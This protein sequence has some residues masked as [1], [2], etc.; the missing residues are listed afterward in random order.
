M[1]RLVLILAAL[2]VAAP[3]LADPGEWL[4]WNMP[5]GTYA[6]LPLGTDLTSGPGTGGKDNNGAFVRIFGCHFGAT[7]GPSTVTIG[8]VEVVGYPVWNDHEIAVQLGPNVIT[9]AI[10]VTTSAGAS[11][12]LETNGSGN[13]FTFTVRPGNIYFVDDTSPASPGSGTYD[14]P[15]RSPSSFMDNSPVINRPPGDILYIR[16]GTYAGQYMYPFTAQWTFDDVNTGGTAGNPIAFVGYPG[17][18]PI[19]SGQTHVAKWR[20]TATFASVQHIVFANMEL[21]GEKGP[22]NDG[23]AGCVDDEPGAADIRVVNLKS[24]DIANISS[25]GVFKSAADD[26]VFLFNES[27][28]QHGTSLSH[29]FYP[30]NGGDNLEIGWNYMHD[31]DYVGYVVSNHT[32]NINID[33]VHSQNV[34][35]HDNIVRGNIRGFGIGRTGNASTFF[36][37]NN[38]VAVYGCSS[39][40]G[41]M[42][43]SGT[44]DSYHNTYVT[45][46]GGTSPD[47]V[48][49]TNPS[50][51]TGLNIQGGRIRNNILISNGTA[52]YY[53]ALNNDINLENNVDHNAYYGNGNANK[54]KEVAPINADPLFVD[55]ATLDFHLQAG[56]PCRDAGS[57]AVAG[58]PGVFRDIN[59]VARGSAYDCGAYEYTA[60]EAPVEFAG[61]PSARRVRTPF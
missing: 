9:G 35:I 32:D 45:L 11:T 15:W 24:H 53:S 13:A 2:L 26:N 46:V 22:Q 51:T 58:L 34:R 10:V 29:D 49:S 28:L 30:S 31:S 25:S 61:V 20:N 33:V 56:S 52:A 50:P 57:T 8:G 7:R 48:F 27:Y 42:H 3:A 18:R 17:E 38:D 59:G 55:F 36:I 60:G 21:I 6:P 14:D 54:A 5:V 19:M 37:W 44:L 23:C 4:C 1:T 39:C 41:Q 16:S 43:T 47:T 40:Y 12:M